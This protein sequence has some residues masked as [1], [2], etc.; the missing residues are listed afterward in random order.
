VLYSIDPTKGQYQY[1]P[2]DQIAQLGKG[3]DWQDE[4]F[5][6]APVQNHQLSI[7]GGNAKTRYNV[8]G[9]FFKQDGI[10]TNTDFKRLSGRANLDIVAS[11]RL[12]IST[13][14][15][16]SNTTS[17]IAPA[18]IISA[19]LTMPPTASIYEADGGYT[20]RNPFENIFS[21][22]IAALKEQT[23][24][25]SG[26]RLFGTASGEYTI[27]DGLE[28]KVLVG[29]D[30]ANSR[31]NSYIPTTIFEGNGI[32]GAASF[33]SVRAISWL[34]ENTLL[35][36]KK[37]GQHAVDAVAGFT[38]QEYTR[39]IVRAGAQ[40]FV[41]DALEDNSLQSGATLVRPYSDNTHW[42]LHS[43]LGRVNYNF[44]Q[45]Y[46]V[47]AS[48]RADGSSRFGS[49][50]KWGY[51]PSAALSWKIS[52]EPFFDQLSNVISD[53]KIR[54]SF[55]T[56]GNL[57]IGEYQSLATLTSLNYL[58]GNT[59][60][61]GF[62][63]N[64]LP[65]SNLGWETTFQYDAGIDAGLFKNRIVLTLDGY[66]K[67]TTDLLLNV[68]IPWTTGQASLLQNY[69]SVE[70]KG[71]E[72][73]LNTRNAVSAFQWNTGL[74]VSFNRNK[75]LSIG[76]GARTYISGNYIIQIG[77]PLGL[78]YGV[79]TDGILQ[80]KDIAEKGKY[81][82]STAPKGGD[83][84]YK[85]I[86]GDSTFT[87]AA[88]RTIVGNAQPNY[89]FGFSNDFS[90]K[91]F[92]V[93]VFFQGV[94]GNQILNTN[95]QTLELF[96]GQQNASATALQ[97]WTEAAPSTTI[98]RA[99]LDP[100][101]LF[102]DRFVEDGSFVRLKTLTI[103]YTI[104]KAVVQHIKLSNLRLY[105]IGQNL[106]TWTKYTGFDPEITTGSNVAPGTDA[107][108]YPVARTINAGLTV[109]F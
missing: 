13:N 77:Q 51:F 29:T 62:T 101:P 71:V 32:G 17:N 4:A 6:T 42:V 89:I 34:N 43:Y 15:T 94:Q 65:N 22:P 9:N 91:G 82:G 70:N 90:W 73:G 54:T 27:A 35:Y 59:V 83:R 26:L 107:G 31:E 11:S 68:E 61:T 1:L 60:L 57:E 103:G 66:Y 47:T 102:S 46:F 80:T 23:N 40:Q 56:T 49:G 25:V 79:V 87:S 19:L 74:N 38:Q 16:A 21:N 109:T 55:G 69:G 18:G 44:A 39:D 48:L 3:T 14:L 75:V 20:L 78:F 41:S 10:I 86:N 95:K 96:T 106:F 72:I 105:V 104:P 93:S 63:P 24:Q 64:R 12:K 100:A 45:K 58:F 8:S 76:N 98:P 108:I 84:L 37:W 53:L 97:R 88:D 36:T 52:N 50:N 30:V 85:D 2:Q 67:K 5:R 7:S 92:D 33:G 81:T 28:F 99:K